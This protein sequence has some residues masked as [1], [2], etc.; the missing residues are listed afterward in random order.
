MNPYWGKHIGSFFTVLLKRIFL[1]LTGNLSIQDLATD[2][3]Q[4]LILLCIAISSSLV[5][6][7][8]VLRKMTMQANAL[9]HTV[10]CGILVSHLICNHTTHTLTG[11]MIASLIT[12]LITISLIQLLT[13]YAQVQEDA[14]IGLVFTTLFALG[15]VGV[16]MYGRNMHIGTEIVMGNIDAL[17]LSDC[18]ISLLALFSNLA[19]TLVFFPTMRLLAFDTQ[20]AKSLGV[21]IAIFEL[22]LIIQT[23]I[24]TTAAFRA[25]GAL[26]VLAFFVGPTLTARLFTHKLRTLLILS[27]L[28]SVGCSLCGVALARHILS[29]YNIPLS[30][31]AL[32]STLITCNY[33]IALPL[34][35]LYKTIKHKELQKIPHTKTRVPA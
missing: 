19:I 35:K 32:I 18:N 20:F 13:R 15:I 34:S 22:L 9:S 26:L 14:S 30:T 8:L 29:L 5:G 21:N 28:S 6:C 4:I 31:S 25:V 33:L 11:Y 3:L 17:S 16:S 2:E 23:A 27:C 12:A 1:F 7:F 24:T 10:L